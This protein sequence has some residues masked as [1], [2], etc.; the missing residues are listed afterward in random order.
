[1]NIIF[2][3]DSPPKDSIALL[4][5]ARAVLLQQQFG[6]SLVDSYASSTSIAPS[7]SVL[8]PVFSSIQSNTPQNS[9]VICSTSPEET[10]NN[11]IKN[12]FVTNESEENEI[13]SKQDSKI[14]KK[15]ISFLSD[16]NLQKTNT[17][18]LPYHIIAPGI[19]FRTLVFGKGKKVQSGNTVDIEILGS[20]SDG[21]IYIFF[22]FLY[23]LFFYCYV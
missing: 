20:E 18:P 22:F 2:I 19:A 17:R 15:D 8:Y 16:F 4:E 11:D 14:I 7:T 23:L 5:T 10:K 13:S 12:S 1:M 6:T 9:S 21:Y 3:I